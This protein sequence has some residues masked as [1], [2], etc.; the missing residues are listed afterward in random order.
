MS[1]DNDVAKTNI[2][3]MRHIDTDYHDDVTMS[4]R[5]TISRRH[6]RRIKTDHVIRS[7]SDR[8]RTWL[9]FAK[10]IVDHM[11]WMHTRSDQ[12]LIAG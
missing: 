5:A 8:N 7:G 3:T 10:I 1:T 2:T 6:Q 11:Q 12:Y 4:H 9:R